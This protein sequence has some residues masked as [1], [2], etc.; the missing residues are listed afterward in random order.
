L[1]PLSTPENVKRFYNTFYNGLGY[2]AEDVNLAYQG[3]ENTIE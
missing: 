1:K 2:F 3:A